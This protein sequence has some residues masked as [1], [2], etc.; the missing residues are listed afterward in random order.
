[1]R[2]SSNFVSPGQKKEHRD[3]CYIQS[4][5]HSRGE[6]QFN[7]TASPVGILK[8]TFSK[9]GTRRLF[10]KIRTGCLHVK[11][12]SDIKKSMYE[13]VASKCLYQCLTNDLPKL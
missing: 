7:F 9:N 5:H 4:D 6:W 8:W 10:Q 2:L 3:W 12:T 1:M 11:T 13:R